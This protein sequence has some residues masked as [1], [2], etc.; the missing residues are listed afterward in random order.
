MTDASTFKKNPQVSVL[1][2][3][4]NAEK[5]LA[6]CLDSVLAQDFAD[7]E[8][9]IS[10]NRSTDGTLKIIETYASRDARV[11]WWQNSK[12]VGL[13]PN[14][15]LCLQKASGQYIKYVHADDK[16]LST[17]AI[18]QMAQALDADPGISIVAS[19]SYTLDNKSQP[20]KLRNS[21]L[22]SR[23]MDGKQ[24]IVHCVMND[25]N[26]IGEPSVVMFRRDQAGRGYDERYCQL[27]DLEFWFH[28]LENGR[29]AYLAEPLCAFREHDKQQSAFN[30]KAGSHVQDELMLAQYWL[31]RPQLREVVGRQG[32][33]EQIHILR[34]RYGERAQPFIGEAM[35]VLAHW[36]TFYWLKYKVSK[37]LKKLRRSIEKRRAELKAMM[38]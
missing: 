22:R 21:F 18:R 11:R 36:Y 15:N 2:P 27:V 20:T 26:F 14:H 37:P 3:V 9:L 7:M 16:L 28:L 35:G 10:D 1:V 38:K 29:F 34:K 31:N 13:A 8:I 6:E 12:N 25:G 17:S 30:R 32:I 24:V 19:A 4:Y 23:V 5:Y 33:Y